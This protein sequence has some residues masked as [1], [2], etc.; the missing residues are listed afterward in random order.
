[1]K[2]KILLLTT[3]TTLALAACSSAPT[4]PQ[5]NAGVLQEVQN[6]DVYPNTVNNKAQLNKLNDKCVIEFTGHLE[7]GKVV[8]Q[9]AFKGLTLFSAGSAV[10]AKD[11]TSTA[12]KF[13]LHDQDVQKNFLSLRKNFAQAALDQC[14]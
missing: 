4:I 10:F 1:M 6:V 3:I 2:F 8:E 7:N 11:G 5:L 12:Q 14:N 9:W 13:D